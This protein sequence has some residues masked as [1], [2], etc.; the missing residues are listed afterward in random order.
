MSLDT[1]A[2]VPAASKKTGKPGDG[3]TG[4]KGQDAPEDAASRFQAMMQDAKTGETGQK[5][6]RA[7]AGNAEMTA[8]E[9]AAAEGQTEGG[10]AAS[11]D[12]GSQALFSTKTLTDA[13]R[14]ASQNVLSS[15]T[16]QN[17]LTETGENG[18]ETADGTVKA[19]AVSPLTMASSALALNSALQAPN[20]QKVVLP[21][22][23]QAGQPAG[24]Q[25]PGVQDPSLAGDAQ[26]RDGG[27]T[28]TSSLF[29]Q[30]GIEPERVSEKGAGGGS[31]GSA[32]P[33]DVTGTVKVLRQ[34]THFAPNMRLSPAQQVG[35]QIT[36]FLKEAAS[37]M[38][39]APDGLTAKAEGPVLKT[40]DIQLTPHELGTVK[41]SLRMVG[42]NVEVS[43]MASKAHTAELLKHDRQLLD[44]MLRTTGFKADTITI[45]TADDRITVQQSSSANS[46]NSATGQNGSGNGAAGNGQPQSFGGNNPGQQDGRPGG[47]GR[48]TVFNAS[49]ALK[50]KGHEEDAGNSLSDGIYL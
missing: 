45:Q 13:L 19:S 41:V 39:R 37:Q 36:G 8:E 30:F 29:S 50:G 46:G 17:G 32:L 21:G 22:A 10:K 14:Q 18:G 20:A 4:S 33:D 44:Q 11:A 12:A 16:A 3:R 38:S 15:K 31:N 23:A 34:E 5:G 7:K 1:H 43:L 49:E 40:L 6:N 35:D 48:D 27:K 24:S 47:D 2:L 42:D 28:G 26:A 25:Q 9:K